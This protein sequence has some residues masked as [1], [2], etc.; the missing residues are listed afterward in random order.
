MLAQNGTSAI[1]KEA[2]NHES[3]VVLRETIAIAGLG[4]AD[5]S[6]FVDDDDE[7]IRIILAGTN[8]TSRTLEKWSDMIIIHDMVVGNYYDVND[9]RM[10]LNT[11]G[12]FA[13]GELVVIVAPYDRDSPIGR[14]LCTSSSI[15]HPEDTLAC[16]I[17]MEKYGDYDNNGGYNV[18]EQPSNCTTP[19][20]V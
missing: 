18:N 4:P 16:I 2:R 3:L 20:G 10:R 14:F 12:E 13:S 7:V 19:N 9:T 5:V 17:N 15:P 11:R 8:R 1:S 6:M